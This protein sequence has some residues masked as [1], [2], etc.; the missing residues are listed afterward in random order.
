VGAERQG[1]GERNT[2]G[3]FPPEAARAALLCTRVEP[4]QR[5][6]RYSQ[7]SNPFY[8]TT[9]ILKISRVLF[10]ENKKIER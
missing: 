5:R 7:R 1:A 2:C 10:G 6:A 8:T 4:A 3:E 9:E